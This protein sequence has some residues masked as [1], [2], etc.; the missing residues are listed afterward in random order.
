MRHSQMTLPS[1]STSVDGLAIGV[2]ELSASGD[3]I[4][5]VETNAAAAALWGRSPQQVRGCSPSDFGMGSAAHTQWL[6][7]VQLCLR[8]NAPVRFDYPHATV[9]DESVLWLA[10]TLSPLLAARRLSFTLE[11]TSP[12]ATLATADPQLL[13]RLLDASTDGI[14]ALTSVRDAA[15]TIVDYEFLF[16]N[17][18]A[19]VILGRRL[20]SGQSLRGNFPELERGDLLEGYA[21]AIARDESVE[22]EVFRGETATPAW[23]ELTAVKLGDGLALTLRSLERLKQAERNLR[24]SESALQEF[25]QITAASLLTVTER[26][27]RLLAMGCRRFGL[28]HG[29]VLRSS[30]PCEIVAAC[31]LGKETSFA[32]GGQIDADEVVFLDV[33]QSREPLSCN[34]LGSGACAACG[35]LEF[36]AY[37]AARIC[38]ARAPQGILVFGDRMPRDRGFRAD[39]LELIKLMAQWIGTQLEYQQAQE[40]LR[41]ELMRSLLLKTLVREIRSCMRPEDIFQTTATQVGAA[42]RVD[43]C[44]VYTC[45]RD[46]MRDDEFEDEGDL[47]FVAEFLES[48]R[49]SVQAR[50]ELLGDN[51]FVRHVMSREGTVAVTDAPADPLLSDERDLV[52]ELGIRSMLAAR[53]TFGGRANGLLVLHHCD[54]PRQWTENEIRLLV[55]VV[56]HVGVALEQAALLAKLT[57]QNAEL[58]VAREAAEIASRAK[59]EFLATMSHEIRTPMNAVIGMSGLLLDT[60]LTPRQREFAEA[61]RDGG[62][63]LLA[64][65]NDI[66]DFSKIETGNLELEEH[67]FEVRAC[68]ESVL[69]LLAHRAKDKPLEVVGWVRPEVPEHILADETRLRQILVNLVG[70]AIKFTEAGEIVIEIGL[71]RMADASDYHHLLISVRDT[72][73]GI[74]PERMHRLFKSFSQVDSSRTRRNMGTGLGLAICQRLA[75]AMGGQI[76]VMSGEAIAGEPPADWRPPSESFDKGTTFFVTI[77]GF[78]IRVPQEPLPQAQVGKRVLVVS[79]NAIQR[80]LLVDCCE[81]WQTVATV[82]ATVEAA[83]DG[84]TAFDLGVLDIRGTVT[85]GVALAAKL[86][87]LL[88]DDR[89]PL[90]LLYPWGTSDADLAMVAERNSLQG[91]SGLHKPIRQ[92]QLQQIMAAILDRGAAQPQLLPQFEAQVP[93]SE[94][95]FLRLLVAEDNAVNQKVILRLLERLGYR[96]DIAG[97]GLETL[98]ALERQPYDVVLLDVQ[99]PEMDGIETARTIKARW[100]EASP[101]LV[102]VTANATRQDREECL[103]A[104]MDDYASKPLT[105]ESLAAA[106]ERCP[107]PPEDCLLA[108][109]QPTAT[110]EIDPMTA[111]T[112]ASSLGDTDSMLGSDVL[113]LASLEALAEM[114]GPEGRTLVAATIDIFLEET[115]RLLRDLG[116]AIAAGDEVWALRICHSLKSSSATLGAPKLSECCSVLEFLGKVPSAT[117]IEELKTECDRALAALARVRDDFAATAA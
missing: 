50:P 73:I 24:E 43:R 92:R 110:P 101:W 69:D 103:A 74:P 117:Q 34:V 47:A 12:P 98:A 85:D 65:V 4:L 91:I 61:I 36:S 30:D 86:R 26:F 15:G 66:L 77:G 109:P 28:E 9:S 107:H 58:A 49:E 116:K 40:S 21:R 60:P 100:P 97:N 14:A 2:L 44:I 115:P 29:L 104:G 114:Y 81:R 46:D 79:H 10:A 19:E 76:W 53:T 84:G 18:A 55:D 64:I 72:G 112:T 48:G 37:L 20:L 93:L 11:V 89:L 8:I 3:S 17:R 45:M 42:F 94:R 62:D 25:S 13:L 90:L 71:A 67:P 96:A 32:P 80:N 99:M 113:D 27:E 102:A 106:L 68:L 87:C 38:V 75:Q 108:R 23:I 39:E 105:L 82:V 22:R 88:G 1:N 51:H 83:A 33:L 56:D 54:T 6:T 35:T 16:A 52:E 31:T 95:K 5:L 111:A 59:G 63:V 41:Q 78:S 57:A 7:Y 70:N